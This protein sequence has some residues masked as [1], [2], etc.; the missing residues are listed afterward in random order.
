MT[1]L[2]KT[3]TEEKACLSLEWNAQIEILCDK[4]KCHIL[5]DILCAIARTQFDRNDQSKTT[6]FE[7]TDFRDS[8][9]IA[10]Q[11]KVR[12]KGVVKTAQQKYRTK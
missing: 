6:K 4:A 7:A 12:Q 1:I 3:S 5:F 11:R 9:H 10:F 2:V 8:R